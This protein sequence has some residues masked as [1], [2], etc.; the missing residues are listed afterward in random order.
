[1]RYALKRYIGKK[2]MDLTQLPIAKH[3]TVELE[4]DGPV[5]TR[6]YGMG[7]LRVSDQPGSNFGVQLCLN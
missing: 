6:E 3:C 4:K 5:L 1:M 2:N 7:F